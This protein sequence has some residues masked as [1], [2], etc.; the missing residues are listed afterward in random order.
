MI[1][2]PGEAPCIIRLAFL[3]ALGLPL[4]KYPSGGIFTT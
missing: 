1:A 3:L 4:E 2:E